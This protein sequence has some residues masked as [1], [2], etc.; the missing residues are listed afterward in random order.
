M[1]RTLKSACDVR[2]AT[3]AGARL[4]R[5][6]TDLVLLNPNQKPGKKLEALGSEA[7]G[8]PVR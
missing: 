1:A 7:K 3:A 6:H 2:T 4:G 8:A 5:K